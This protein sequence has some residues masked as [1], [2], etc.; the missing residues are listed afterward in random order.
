[1]CSQ[2]LYVSHWMNNWL[3]PKFTF[4]NA[5]VFKNYSLVEVI[6]LL[7]RFS[8]TKFFLWNAKNTDRN[9][10][11]QLSTHTHTL[12]TQRPPS[13]LPPPPHP[14][15]GSVSTLYRAVAIKNKPNKEKIFVH[16]FVGNWSRAIVVVA[17]WYSAKAAF[18]GKFWFLIYGQKFFWPIRLQHF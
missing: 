14:Y 9:S 13:P 7:I 10:V 3:T 16:I 15:K 4:Y 2:Q 1:M 12:N 18:F 11:N 5:L 17:C 6:Y 8:K